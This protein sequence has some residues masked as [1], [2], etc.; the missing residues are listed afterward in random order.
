MMVWGRSRVAWCT[1]RANEEED[2]YVI[3]LVQFSH[4]CCSNWIY[5]FS[6]K[7]TSSFSFLLFFFFSLQCL[8]DIF[9]YRSA[10]SSRDIS[11]VLQEVVSPVSLLIK[12]WMPG[13]SIICNSFHKTQPLLASFSIPRSCAFW[14]LNSLL[15]SAYW[16]NLIGFIFYAFAKFIV[17]SQLQ[18]VVET[19]Y[20]FKKAAVNDNFRFTDVFW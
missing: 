10:R 7:V 14:S 17:L 5:Q 4:K 3:S 8:F 19:S 9:C 2:L 16:Y 15:S 20:V 13:Q 12:E 18:E 1:C 11:L 6:L